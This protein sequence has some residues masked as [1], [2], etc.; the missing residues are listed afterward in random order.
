M[1][2]Q[3]VDDKPVK[4]EKTKALASPKLP[5]QEDEFNLD[6]SGIMM[7]I[8]M[9][10]MMAVLG[11]FIKSTVQPMSTYATNMTFQGK[12]I[13]NRQ[14]ILSTLRKVDVVAM[15]GSGYPWSFANIENNG[16]NAVK[17]GVNG[18]TDMFD[19]LAGRSKSINR[20]G[21]E[22]RISSFFFKCADT[23][24]AQIVI[25]GEF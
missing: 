23:E 6:D 25:N 13:V 17:V 10:M 18:S 24:S 12:T 19:I 21:A 16:P 1:A 3:L 9:V 5:K 4:L 22:E 14:T 2:R 11:S 15:T 20:L 8:M 7:I